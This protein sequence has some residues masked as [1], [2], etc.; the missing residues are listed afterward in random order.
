MLSQR[1][2]MN[3]FVMTD[4]CPVGAYGWGAN[5]T[6]RS[7]LKKTIKIGANGLTNLYKLYCI[8]LRIHSLHACMHGRL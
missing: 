4:W 3:L 7:S 1:E 8:G 2:N 6:A 5:G